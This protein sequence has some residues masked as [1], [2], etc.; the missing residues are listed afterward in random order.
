MVKYL[1]NM[2]RVISVFRKYGIPRKGAEK[3]FTSTLLRKETSCLPPPERFRRRYTAPGIAV[4]LCTGDGAEIICGGRRISLGENDVLTVALRS[5]SVTGTG[6]TVAVFLSPDA[7]TPALPELT[8]AIP[9]IIH[10]GEHRGIKQLAE[11]IPEAF[12]GDPAVRDAKLHALAGLLVIRLSE[13]A[14]TTPDGST[15]SACAVYIRSH[16]DQSLTPGEIAEKLNIPEK[17]LRSEFAAVY[18]CTPAEFQRRAKM[19]HAISLMKESPDMLIKEI[20]AAVGYRDELWFTKPSANTPA[21]LREN[22]G[23]G[24]CSEKTLR[25]SPTETSTKKAFRSEM[26]PT[27]SA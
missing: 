16:I 23:K 12:Y 27:D 8:V 1:Y 22:T 17:K 11:A 3:C 24:F 18:G 26:S 7:E 9:E 13:Y 15:V 25:H 10:C 2:V 4:I 19:N 20:A 5:G 21:S 14:D 6:E